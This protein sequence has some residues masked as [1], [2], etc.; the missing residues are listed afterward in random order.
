MT[1]RLPAKI[2][3]RLLIIDKSIDLI[4]LVAKIGIPVWGSVRIVEALAGKETAAEFI[5]KVFQGS[6]S[7]LVQWATYLALG[8]W[9]I[10]ERKLR[11]KKTESL[12]GRIQ[13]LEKTI[14]ERR[15]T[16]GLLPTGET[17]PGDK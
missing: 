11:H 12:H 6:G 3:A 16:S 15:T 2:G 14:D 9:A 7:S 4:G 17:N 13:L 5:L 1:G 8:G 10:V